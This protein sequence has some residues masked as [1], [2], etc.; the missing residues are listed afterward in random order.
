MVNNLKEK[1]QFQKLLKLATT[2]AYFQ[3]IMNPD[4]LGTQTYA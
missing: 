1:V 2:L 4:M 3:Y